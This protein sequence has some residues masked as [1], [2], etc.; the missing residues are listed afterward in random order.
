MKDD[1]LTEVSIIVPF[2][3]EKEYAR[4]VISKIYSYFLNKKID[5][6][7]IAVDDSTDETWNI[8]K[9]MGKVYKN[10]KAV[11]GW[12]PAGYGKAIRKGFMTATGDI[13]IPFNGDMC[14]SLDDAM[15]YIKMI[16]YGRYDMAFGSRYMKGGKVVNYPSNKVIISK[17]GNLFLRILFGIKCSDVTN[18]FKGFSRKAVN[19]INPKADSYE[20]G[21]ELA[22]KGVRN[23]LTY[24]TIPIS[25]T[26]RKYGVS[27]MRLAKSIKNHFIMATKIF[28][29]INL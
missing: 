5:F 8:L 2:K 12:K 1:Y 24:K 15:K 20:I 16:K 21:L 10:F 26:G 14:D 28:F 23:G 7:I 25:W 17:L 3:N 4:E 11:K 6:E 13:L 18:T 19:V 27:K 9:N 29:G 22:L